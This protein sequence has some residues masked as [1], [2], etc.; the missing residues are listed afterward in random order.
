MK[1]SIV[2]LLLASTATV[3]QANELN[4]TQEW[5]L[6][7]FVGQSKFDVSKTDLGL[8]AS[9]D[10]DDSG[11]AFKVIAGYQISEHFAIEGGYADLGELSFGM[12][13]Q[14]AEPNWSYDVDVKVTGELNGFLVNLVGKLPLNDATHLYAKIGAFSWDG[15]VT[16]TYSGVETHNDQSFTISQSGS[17]SDDGTD[18]FYGVGIGY[19]IDNFMLR[20]EFEKMDSDG[21][22]TDVISIGATYHF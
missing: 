3:A 20:A 5:Y 11:T 7:G 15:K 16:T 17:E 18:V 8:P 13:E 4:N 2:A 19:K 9:V 12:N 6:G 21:E 10:L 1:R 22:D 14:Y